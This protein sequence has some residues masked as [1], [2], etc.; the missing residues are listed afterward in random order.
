MPIKPENKRRYPANWNEI[1][2][3]ILDRAEHC[4]ERCH[5]NNY[6][7]IFRGQCDDFGTFMTADGHVYDATT[8]FNL[9]WRARD[10]YCWHKSTRIVLTIAH[11]DHTPEHCE[12]ENLQ[13]LCQRCHLLHDIDHHN[14]TRRKTMRERK[15]IG[16]LFI[17]VASTEI[18]EPK[19]TKK[20]ILNSVSDYSFL[21]GV[22]KE[23]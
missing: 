16:D 10:D 21:Y 3:R 4:C 20:K 23:S 7:E 6:A 8:G 12:D 2:K 18:H 17:E 5:I 22:P 11:L 19:R 13:A 14:E 9:G 1:R 15:A